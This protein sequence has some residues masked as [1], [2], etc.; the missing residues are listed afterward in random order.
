MYNKATFPENSLPAEKPNCFSEFQSLHF[1]HGQGASQGDQLQP[2]PPQLKEQQK[3]IFCYSRTENPHVF[4]KGTAESSG[5]SHPGRIPNNSCLLTRLESHPHP[6]ALC[7]QW[8]ICFSNLSPKTD[9]PSLS[10]AVFL[11]DS[12]T[13]S[14]ICSTARH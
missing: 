1:P 8:I 7:A 2:C 5:E 10:R 14:N 9:I 4:C 6:A 3:E 11:E 12:Q 13:C